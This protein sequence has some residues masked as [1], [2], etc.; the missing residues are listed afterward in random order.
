MLHIYNNKTPV[1]LSDKDRD[2]VQN[3]LQKMHEVLSYANMLFK[4]KEKTIV[5]NDVATILGLHS[6]Y[7]KELANLLQYQDVLAEEEELKRQEIREANMKIQALQRELGGK[8]SSEGITA[9]LRQ[10]DAAFRSWY[11]KEG[12]SY[13]ADSH[14]SAYCLIT[15]LT[16]ALICDKPGWDTSLQDKTHWMLL[17]TDHNRECL[18][19][20]LQ[21]NFPNIRICSFESRRNI[22]NKQKEEYLLRT[23]VSIP[24]AD[25]MKQEVKGE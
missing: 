16:E 14:F 23:T 9:G 1:N 12:F 5:R 3:C 25:L 13:A 15:Q 20:L 17:D 21:H 11:K 6:S 19:T 10:L 2:A 18:T 4:D 22:Y 8:Q 24:F 7:H